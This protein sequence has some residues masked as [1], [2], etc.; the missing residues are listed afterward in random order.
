MEK[1]L[2]DYFEEFVA[3]CS[4][5]FG[6]GKERKLKITSNKKKEKKIDIEGPNWK[7]KSAEPS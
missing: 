3:I 2:S 4:E 6:G 1:L 7:T 5:F